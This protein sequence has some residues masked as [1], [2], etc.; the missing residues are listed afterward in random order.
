EKS[1]CD[2][3]ER[4]KTENKKIKKFYRPWEIEDDGET[5]FLEQGVICLGPATRGG[6]G[7]RCIKGNAPCRGC[8]GPPPDVSDPG[9]KMMSAIATMIDANDPEEIENIIEQIEDPAGTFY[10]FS[11]PSSII[12][13]K[14]I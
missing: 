4:K 9:A 1:Q 7:T 11:L 14:L 8:Y 13:R 2:E 5:C 6:C 3:C 12:R 10:R